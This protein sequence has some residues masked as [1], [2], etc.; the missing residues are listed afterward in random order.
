MSLGASASVSGNGLMSLGSD[1]VTSNL[2]HEIYSGK[3]SKIY[4][5]ND[6]FP[7]SPLYFPHAAS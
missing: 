1:T 4:P 6:V 5:V 3:D 2:H 7:G